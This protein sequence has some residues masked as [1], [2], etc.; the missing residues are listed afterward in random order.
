MQQDISSVKVSEVVTKWQSAKSDYVRQWGQLLASI[1]GS[2]INPIVIDCCL[3]V[4]EMVSTAVN[5]MNGMNYMC[6][7]LSL[8]MVALVLLSNNVLDLC[9]LR[10]FARPIHNHTYRLLVSFSELV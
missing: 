10:K 6:N 4:D 5:Q 1:K 7:K 8:Q 2:A 9:E 3:P